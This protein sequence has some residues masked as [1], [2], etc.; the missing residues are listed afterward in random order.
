MWKQA[1]DKENIFAKDTSDKVLLSKMHNEL[2]KLN[3]KKTTNYEMG[4]KPQRTSH[5]RDIQIVNKHM[6]RCSTPPVIR[7]MQVTIIRRYHY[8]ASV[9]V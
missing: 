1:T 4:Q 8:I 3:N 2:L 7:E 6:E 5:Q 9:V